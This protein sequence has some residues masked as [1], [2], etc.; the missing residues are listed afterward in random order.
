MTADSTTLDRLRIVLV[1]PT[2]PANVGAVGRAMANMGLCDLVVVSPRHPLTHEDTVAYATH[3]HYVIEQA[4]VV[5]SVEE[6]LQDCVRTYATSAKLGLYRR[7][8]ALP[9]AQA[10]AEALEQARHGRIAVAFGPE[11]YG[12]YNRELLLFDR[13]VT[14][15]T[16]DAFPVLNLAAAVTV[17]SY[18]LRRAYL[19]QQD[20]PPLPMAIENDLASDGRKQILFTKLFDALEQIDFF[21]RQA[22]DKLKYAL[23]HLLGRLDMTVHEADVLIGMAQQ[24]RWWVDHHK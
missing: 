8:S 23:R 19:S 1:R 21:D 2:G 6:A 13:I 12:L 20:A 24:I 9:V 10:A 14:I 7:Q 17:V 3:G 5:E 4:R 22:P 11:N 16:D 15:P 18:E